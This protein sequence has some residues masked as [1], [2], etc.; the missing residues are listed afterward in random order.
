MEQW[1]KSSN[2]VLG[3]FKGTN[4][5]KKWI[6]VFA[7]LILPI[8]S[9]TAE[10]KGAEVYIAL[11][12][13]LA[14]GQTPFREIDT[15]YTDLIGLELKRANRLAHYTKTLAFP[16]FTTGDVLNLVQTQDAQEVLKNAT[17]VTISAGA[18]DL[19]GLMRVNPSNG[20]IAYE[21]VQVNFALNNVRKN[22]G[23]IIKEVQKVAPNAKIYVM[24]YYFAY[25]HLQETQKEGIHNELTTLHTILKNEAEANGATFVSVEEAF[26]GKEKEL[27]PNTSDVHPTMEG[28]RL[29]ANAFFKAYKSGMEVRPGELP[30]PNPL[31]FENLI[32]SRQESTNSPVSRVEGYEDYLSLTELRALA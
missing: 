16:G 9:I 2:K 28:Y 6:V 10:A 12:D 17:L 20:T 22:I 26:N 5:M 21:Q 15:G 11:G 14:A 30:P 4:P 1:S 13:S 3:L 27:L 32:K 18:N 29:M 24:G 31:S 23:S 7:L 25:P 19:L 8:S